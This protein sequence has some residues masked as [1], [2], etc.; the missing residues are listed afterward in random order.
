M[1]ADS[2]PFRKGYQ[3]TLAGS[4]RPGQQTRERTSESRSACSRPC[5]VG[6]SQECGTRKPKRDSDR[7]HAARGLGYGHRFGTTGLGSRTAH[8]E[9]RPVRVPP[10][11]GHPSPPHT[12]IQFFSRARHLHSFPVSQKLAESYSQIEW[13]AR[14]TCRE[15]FGTRRPLVSLTDGQY[16]GT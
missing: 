7:G 11:G 15:R 13:V 2:G 1:L 4:R 9:H 14:T 10:P 12:C 6:F 5:N 8:G 16:P 3:G